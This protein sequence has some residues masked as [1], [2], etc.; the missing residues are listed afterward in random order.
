MANRTPGRAGG[1]VIVPFTDDGFDFNSAAAPN[2]YEEAL[3]IL[4]EFEGKYYPVY[5]IPIS[6]FAGI[7]VTG[8]FSTNDGSDE[9]SISYVTVG[10]QASNS[11]V[12]DGLGFAW[13]RSSYIP[14]TYD[15]DGVV[16]TQQLAYNCYI[17]DNNILSEDTFINNDNLVVG[18]GINNYIG[19]GN[20]L[21]YG[22]RL[23]LPNTTYKFKLQISRNYEIIVWILDDGLDFDLVEDVAYGADPNDGTPNNKYGYVAKRGATDPLYSPNADGTHFG[24]SVMNTQNYEWRYSSLN[25]A[26]I[27][28]DFPASMF[29]LDADPTYL[30]DGSDFGVYWKGWGQWDDAEADERGASVFIRNILTDEWEL[31]GSNTAIQSSPA[32]DKAITGSY[33]D[34]ATYR[35]G[36]NFV[37]LLAVAT[38][39][40]SSAEINTNYVNIDNTTPSGIHT[41]GMVDI[42]V[43][44]PDGI[45]SESVSKTVGGT[46]Q[47]STANGFQL[48][49]HSISSITSTITGNE[50]VEGEDYSLIVS[51]PKNAWSTS[52][53]LTLSITNSPANLTI[54]YRYY[55]RGAEIQAFIE[56]E[57]YRNPNV[58][59]LVKIK[60]PAIITVKAMEYRGDVNEDSLK[61]VIS[62]WINDLSTTTSTFEVSDFINMLYNAN[63]E[64]VN[65]TTLDI[66]R[67]TYDYEGTLLQNDES[68]SDSYTLSGLQAFYTD[69]LELYGLT[70]LG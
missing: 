8:T 26:S 66:V 28:D 16:A 12:G 9:G 6:K 51:E 65:L 69:R 10:R 49:V 3:R 19:G 5:H 32:V 36:N 35:D 14:E 7:E 44:D 1:E 39:A 41:G 15:A 34:I 37:T 43:N 25:I 55:S 56:S 63:V 29:K 53:S 67:R 2:A 33:E 60:P 48:P 70:K 54:N 13:R 11:A 58:S 27:T 18:G 68:I 62:D 24:I 64:Y 30:V 42:Y 38:K 17:V 50:L 47:L 46:M 52:T 45:E 22:R 59:P 23:I 20:F 40:E 57:D 4:N 31:V 61:T 21:T